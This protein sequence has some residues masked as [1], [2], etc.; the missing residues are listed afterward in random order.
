M[1]C[2]CQLKVFRE[3]RRQST[4]KFSSATYSEPKSILIEL[5][6]NILPMTERIDLGT[7]QNVCQWRG[8]C[9]IAYS[10]HWQAASVPSA[11]REKGCGRKKRAFTE[12][13]GFQQWFEWGQVDLNRDCCASRKDLF[14]STITVVLRF[15]FFGVVINQK[16][17]EGRRS[18]RSSSTRRIVSATECL[19]VCRCSRN[20]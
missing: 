2:V 20:V 17:R 11:G 16:S 14:I 9:G 7:A 15:F 18:K 4:R 5:I 1:L 6:V 3:Q 19:F 13:V 8:S 10:P 12:V